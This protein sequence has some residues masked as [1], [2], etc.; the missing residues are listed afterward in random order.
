MPCHWMMTAMDSYNTMMAVC[1]YQAWVSTCSGAP[2]S[3][4]MSSRE[5]E[6]WR[7]PLPRICPERC[8]SRAASTAAYPPAVSV[9]PDISLH[10][11]GA[12][13]QEP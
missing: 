5:A 6:L 11:T 8:R 10:T 7:E 2:P 9:R 4:R 13:A 12:L 3:S 1:L